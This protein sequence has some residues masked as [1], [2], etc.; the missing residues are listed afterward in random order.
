MNARKFFWES[1]VFLYGINF[2]FVISTDY[3]FT[4][5]VGVKGTLNFILQ[6][7]NQLLEAATYSY[8]FITL[9]I[10]LVILCLYTYIH[11]VF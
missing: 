2:I 7:F 1:I 4:G 5:T 8:M 3:R 10:L 9:L 6:R 11:V